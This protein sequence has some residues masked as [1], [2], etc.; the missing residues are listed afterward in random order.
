VMGLQMIAEFVE[1]DS[2]LGKVEDLGIDYA[3]GYGIHRPEPLSN[4]YSKGE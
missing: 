3:Q 4:M 2:I 1:T